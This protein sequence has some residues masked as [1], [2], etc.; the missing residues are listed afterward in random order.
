ME[1]MKLVFPLF[2]FTNVPFNSFNKIKFKIGIL[3]IPLY[4]HILIINILHLVQ[5]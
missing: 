1:E 4:T 5:S 3:K 2:N